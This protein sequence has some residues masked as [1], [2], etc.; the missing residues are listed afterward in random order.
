MTTSAT[1]LAASVSS[2]ARISPVVPW[3]C[4]TS[5]PVFSVKAAAILSARPAGLGIYTVTLPES[6]VPVSSA[7]VSLLSEEDW[8]S[9]EEG[10]LSLEELWL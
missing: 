5:T 4:S 9:L 7:L 10:W 2:R 6:S 3:N 1:G 8:L